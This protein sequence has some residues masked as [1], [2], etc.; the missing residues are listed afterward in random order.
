MGWR[1]TAWPL[2]SLPFPPPA[3]VFPVVWGILFA[4][5]GISGARIYL[6]PDSAP[7]TNSL[8]LFLIQ[9]A[10]NFFWSLIFFNLQSYGLA[11]IWLLVLWAQIV[12][13]ILTM[14]QVDSLAAWLQIPYFLWVKSLTCRHRLFPRNMVKYFAPSVGFDHIVK[15]E[16]VL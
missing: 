14:R 13:M 4:L 12:W 3:I 6:S 11:L 1:S 16:I 2:K 15:E 9:L 5:M 10:F 8:R 7:R